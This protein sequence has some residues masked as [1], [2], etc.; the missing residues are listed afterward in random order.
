M[1]LLLVM[2]HAA[3]SMDSEV[4]QLP[5]Q[6]SAS[7]G[8]HAFVNVIGCLLQSGFQS[9]HIVRCEYLLT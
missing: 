9:C 1:A 8:T 4:Q 3:V 5:S 7:L 2:S 6:R